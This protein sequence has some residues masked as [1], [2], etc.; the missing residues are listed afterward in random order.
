VTL[1]ASSAPTGGALFATFLE[2]VPDAVVAVVADGTILF[3]NSQAEALFGY[4]S[5]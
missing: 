5:R 3:V 2:A 4:P 1:A